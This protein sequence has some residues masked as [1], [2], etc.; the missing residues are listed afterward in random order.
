MRCPSNELLAAAAR[1]RLGADAAAR[2]DRHA[3]SCAACRAELATLADLARL[4][5][6]A[7]PAAPDGLRERAVRAIGG[8]G[9]R[10]LVAETGTI[11]ERAVDTALGPAPVGA[12][13]AA[14]AARH[15]LFRA[16]GYDVSVRVAAPRAGH[17]RLSGQVLP[18][19]S[20]PLDA[21]AGVEVG[22]EREGRPVAL[23][24]AN[25]LGEFVVDLLADGAYTAYVE[26]ADGLLV[27]PDI[28]IATPR[29]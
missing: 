19:P 22:L 17:A 29:P 23:V 6:A 25:A 26:L 11:A 3:A 1:R 12:R 27:L 10:R 4:G 8:A 9:W 21:V 2:I 7:L 16:L 20:R 14:P 24:V 5:E 18:G 28:R 13:R 15:M